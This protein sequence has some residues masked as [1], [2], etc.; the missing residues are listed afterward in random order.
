MIRNEYLDIEHRKTK[1]PG[2][3]WIIGLFHRQK[4]SLKDIRNNRTFSSIRS[5]ASDAII[6]SDL[7]LGSRICQERAILEFL[8][9]IEHGELA[10]RHLV[11]NGDVFDS[12]DFRRLKKSHWKILS[13]IRK[14]SGTIRITWISGNHDGPAEIISQLLGV[15]VL[16]ECLLTSGS[17]SILV[18]HGHRFDDFIDTYPRVTLVAD[19]LYRFLQ[20][21][22]HSHRFA[23]FAK[24]NSKIFLRCAEKIRE[25]SISYART[26]GADAVCCGHT[27]HAETAT[28]NGV[29]YFNSGSWTELPCNYLCITEGHIQLETFVPAPSFQPHIAPETGPETAPE[30]AFT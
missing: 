26:M 11:L 20:R 8:K 12:I 18:L 22:D 30:P 29:G 28:G 1:F 5:P 23:R 13:I 10:T 6:I 14:L 17:R 9:R 15:E 16:E 3:K 4:F 7:H 27:H 25:K 21:I 24:S 2:C 19:L